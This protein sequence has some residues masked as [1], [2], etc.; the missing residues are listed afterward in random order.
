VGDIFV[1]ANEAHELGGADETIAQHR[2]DDVKVAV[3][4]WA[5][6]GLVRPYEF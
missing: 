5:A 4:D 3:G 1:A 6:C 2:I